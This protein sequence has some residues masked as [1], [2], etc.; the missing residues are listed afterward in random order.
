M[1]QQ[2]HISIDAMPAVARLREL[3]A[4]PGFIKCPGVYDGL[5]TKC[6]LQYAPDVLYATGAGMTCSRL[7]LPDLAYATQ[8]D[9]VAQAG[10]I[11]SCDRS[12]P[13]IADGE[14]SLEFSLT[15]AAS[16]MPIADRQ[17][18]IILFSHTRRA[19]ALPLK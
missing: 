18:L 9:F 2:H 19:L 4:Q 12:I 8:D 3:L 17:T 1:P 11:A 14:A 10:M 6:A 15:E 13:V 16:E 7:G 5:S